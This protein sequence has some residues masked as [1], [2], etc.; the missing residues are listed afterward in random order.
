MRHCA[1]FLVLLLLAS[2]V[3]ADE[4]HYI[5]PMAGIMTGDANLQYQSSTVLWNLTP[6]EA[7]VQTSAVY[8]FE[9]KAACN[10][11]ESFTI[12]PFGRKVIS[13][14]SCF[15][16]TAALSFTSNEKLNVRTE[17][18][19]H[20]T[21]VNGWDK[22]LV[23]AATSWIDAGVTTIAEGVLREDGPRKANL[24]VINPADTTLTLT[25]EKTRPEFLLS[26]T[27][28]YAVAPHS[29]RFIPIAP[30]IN[31]TP[32]PFMSSVTGRH[33]FKLTGNGPWQGGVSSIYQGPSMYSAAVPLAP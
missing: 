9:G 2:A 31:A 8:P 12:E 14:L 16:F 25:V 3:S 1:K 32:P 28:T 19:T 26:A 18:E 23:E 7:T 11:A 29:T 15:R 5:V 10:M 22:Q 24:I 4:F 33:L 13:P 6:R 17:I 20:R 21:L 27:D 30:L